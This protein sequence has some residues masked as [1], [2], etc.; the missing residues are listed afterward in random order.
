M[1]GTGCHIQL[2][3]CM[4]LGL[5]GLHLCRHFI[6][7]CYRGR[8]A[9]CPFAALF[10]YTLTLIRPRQNSTLAGGHS[11]IALSKRLQDWRSVL[12]AE[13]TMHKCPFYL[14]KA[15]HL[16]L[17]DQGNVMGL[18]DSH[19]RGHHHLHLQSKLHAVNQYSQSES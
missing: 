15:L 10:K 18:L 2:L 4:N 8:Q 3:I 1:R 16:V 6:G 7:S 9:L 13:L 5:Q 11:C 19:S 14:I 12:L 17:Q